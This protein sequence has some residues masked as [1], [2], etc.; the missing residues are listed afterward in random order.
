MGILEFLGLKK[1]KRPANPPSRPEAA[2]QAAVKQQIEQYDAEVKKL[3]REL[4]SVTRKLE[5]LDKDLSRLMREYQ[6]EKLSSALYAHKEAEIDARKAK[7]KAERDALRAQADALMG[8][9]TQLAQQVKS[10]LPTAFRNYS[11]ED[12]LNAA[13]K[14]I[15]DKGSATVG[16]M[17]FTL[18]TLATAYFIAQDIRY[19]LEADN[20]LEGLS[21]AAKVGTGYAIGAAELS[22]FKFIS[23][24]TPVAFVASISLGMCSDKAG[25]CDKQE[26]EEQ[27]RAEKKWH[28]EQEREEMIAIGKFLAKH[29]PGSVRWLEDH[30]EVNNQKLWD[31]TVKQ[32]RHLRHENLVKQQMKQSLRARELGFKDGRIGPDFVSH[33]G[34]KNWPEVKA[35]PVPE[36]RFTEL[37]QDYKIGF[38][39]GN[40]KMAAV[41]ERARRL[42]YKDGKLGRQAHRDDIRSWREVDQVLRDGAVPPLFL[43]RL[44][45]EYG[46]AFDTVGQA[47]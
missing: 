6:T 45:K 20:A 31:E 2:D 5:Q 40:A 15:P 10:E 18:V 39:E 25:S 24:S 21:R 1:P 27:K 44:Y 30:Y 9:G 8:R 17:G 16:A 23:K 38:K 47:H 43:N 33:E 11:P 35:W 19:I 7:A 32:A 37:F 13:R 41:L 14:R 26:K 29:A 4:A 34:I 42:G 28:A 3:E 12:L 36:F 22:L 46:D